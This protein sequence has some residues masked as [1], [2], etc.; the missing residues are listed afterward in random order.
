VKP[1][2]LLVISLIKLGSRLLAALTPRMAISAPVLSIRGYVIVTRKKTDFKGQVE[3]R[4]HVTNLYGSRGGYKKI[5][6]QDFHA[7]S[8]FSFLASSIS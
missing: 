5:L 3:G 2:W 6:H 1:A 4:R 7:K 8:P